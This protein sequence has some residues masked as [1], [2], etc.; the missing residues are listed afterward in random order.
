[1]SEITYVLKFLLHLEQIV[2]GG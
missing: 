1:M 2:Q